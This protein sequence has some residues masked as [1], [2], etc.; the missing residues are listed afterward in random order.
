RNAAG[1]SVFTTPLYFQT[2]AGI[3]PTPGN[4][5]PGSS[6]S[7]GP[8]QAS[9]TVTVSWA[10]S[11]GAGDY[12]L[13]VR[14]MATGI[15]VV[16]TFTSGTSY[17]VALDPRTLHGALPASRNAAGESAFTTPLYFQTPATIPAPLRPMRLVGYFTGGDPANHPF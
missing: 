15:L 13:G 10:A 5:T 16:S 14:D 6:T 2:P 9:T 12:D 1:E 17:T 3:P 8:I 7:P 11:P 4:P